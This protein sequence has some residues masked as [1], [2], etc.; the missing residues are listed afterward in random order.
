VA[1]D[2][3]PSR[4]GAEARV[5]PR[6]D[7]VIHGGGGPL[8]AASLES[9]E[10][11]GALLLEGWLDRARVEEL[12]A[13]LGRMRADPDMQRRE[14]TIIE[15][16]FEPEA[17]TVRSIFRVHQI[18]A[19]FGEL[20]RDPELVAIAGQILAGDVYVHQ[21]R[22]N[23]KP[24]LE[25][26]EFHWH[27]DFETWHVEDGL[28]RMRALS[29]AVALSENTEF[30]G[31][32]LTIPGSHRRYVSCPGR[33][34]ENHHKSSLRRQR[35]GVPPRE[36]LEELVA[37]GGMTAHKGPAGSIVI[38]D[39]N[40]MHGSGTNM[41]PRSRSNVFFVYNSVANAAVA[42]FGGT[43][44]RPEFIASRDFTPL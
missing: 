18:S 14:E 30:N 35:Y 8:P 36:L 26:R 12:R 43:A 38:F 39:C 33:T 37:D 13:E 6:R 27:S 24:G 2:L 42:P 32:L 34:P 10:Q 5:L 25:G 16:G 1:E 40:T 31:P 19:V 4:V 11:G 3:Y 29:V 17:E 21:S 28:P 9:F 41:S 15:P 20:V 7:P 22:I 44:P 23:Y